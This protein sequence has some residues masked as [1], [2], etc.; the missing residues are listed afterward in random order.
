MFNYRDVLDSNGLIAR[1]RQSYERR[2][3]QLAMAA[4]VDAAIRAK[5]CLA[6]EAGTGVGKSFAYLVPAI[7]YVVERQVREYDPNDYFELPDDDAEDSTSSAPPESREDENARE[8]PEF[9]LSND[10]GAPSAERRRVVVST[11]TISLQEQL[12]RKDVPFLNSILPFEFTV[13]LAKGRANYICKRR[14][15]NAFRGA[16]QGTLFE[17]DRLSEFRRLGEWLEETT[18]GSKSELDPPIPYDVWDEINCER[19]NCLGRRCKYNADCFFLRARRRVRNASI[20]IVNHA[21]LFSDLAF[22]GGAILPN[23]DVLVLDEAHTIESIAAEHLGMEITEYSVEYLLKRLYNERTRKG[24]LAEELAKTKAAPTLNEPFQEAASRVAEC[25][26]RAGVFFDSLRKWYDARSR[27]FNGRVREKNIVPNNLAEGLKGLYRALCVA[28]DIIEDD[29]RRQEYV[30]AT[31]RVLSFIGAIDG[32]LEQNDEGHAYWLETSK[33]RRGRRISL[34]SA[35]IDVS[36]ILR[37]SL[38][39]AIP[40][41]ITTSA[42][43]TTGDAAT[44]LASA[45]DEVDLNALA[46]DSEHE[47]EATKKAFAF[48]RRRVG[49]TGAPARALGSPFNFREQMTLAL[50]KNLE[51]TDNPLGLTLSERE[52]INDRRRWQAIREYIDETDGG[53]FV[54]FTNTEKMRRATAALAP[55]CAE[56][57]YP[58]YSQSDGTPRQLMVERFKKSERSVLFGVDSFWQGVDVPGAALR[59]VIIVKFP[60]LS[61]RHPLVEARL[62][63]IDESG[64]RSFIDY[65]LPMAIL[66]FK[67]GVGRLIRTR[68][69]SGI[70]VLLDERVHTKSYG[71]NFLRALPDCKRRVDDFSD[72]FGAGTLDIENFGVE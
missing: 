5:K 46:V 66:R 16:E 47:S 23:Y 60:F 38:F 42:T 12:Y 13:A 18:D 8:I 33:S 49:L 41:V 62:K 54:L 20:I 63:A 19:G 34:H 2:P 35:P 58:I 15:E 71:R 68:T 31:E 50:V 28:A 7:L 59:N 27:N 21:L 32:W 4:E 57:N 29:D 17:T 25:R 11:H 10:E 39:N 65:S 48:F 40:S 1:R 52:E 43:L 56:R 70:V 64:G 37:D 72:R 22:G 9:A 36:T 69:D 24:L 30:A 3:A 26:M 55:F 61:W 67:Q 53:A 6:I 51:L 45:S 14:F 44:E